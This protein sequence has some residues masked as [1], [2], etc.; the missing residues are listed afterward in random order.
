MDAE[1]ALVFFSAQAAAL[2]A[3]DFG[4]MVRVELQT[5]VAALCA[6][7][8]VEEA[9]ELVDGLRRRRLATEVDLKPSRIMIVRA[10]SE[11][12]KQDGAV[13]LEFTTSDA[14][15][16]TAGSGVAAAGSGG[17]VCDEAAPFYAA[18]T[19]SGV[20]YD[21]NAGGAVDVFASD[22]YAPSPAPGSRSS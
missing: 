10:R 19:Y 16:T 12:A 18:R 20:H 7:R 9:A 21:L 22:L 6:R 5:M 14:A 4:Q 15:T 8:R 3:A 1:K 11:L 2:P 13:T 17:G